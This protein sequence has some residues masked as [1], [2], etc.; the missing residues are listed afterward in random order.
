[1][2]TVWAL[3]FKCNYK[4]SL[5]SVV[6]NSKE[7]R[8]RWLMAAALLLAAF[9]NQLDGSI[10]NL[11]LPTIQADLN[12]SPSQLQWVMAIYTVAFASGLLP[13]GRFGDV[14]AR[15]RMF[16]GGLIGF[17][18]F[19]IICEIAPNIETLIVARAF[20][21]LAAGMM[22]P[23]VLAIIHVV[24]P[25]DKKGHVIGLF[26]MLSALGA[27]V[28][29]LVGG[30]LVSADVLGLGW[31]AIFL[32]NL[33]FGLISLVGALAFLPKVRSNVSKQAD[34]MGAVLFALAIICLT[35]PLIE[36]REL[37]WP[38]WMFCIMSFSVICGGG[39]VLWQ[40]YL[41][42]KNL[43]QTLPMSLMRDGSFI[44]G[45]FAVT[46]FF[47]GIAGVIL[48]L[49]F[50]LQSGLGF[51]AAQAGITM[52]AFPISVML[53]SLLAGYLGERWLDLRVFGGA[54][55]ILVG[56]LWLQF[57][58]GGA[59]KDIAGMEIQLPLFLTGAGMGSA[60]VALFQNVLSR[61]SGPDAGAGS[62]VL[63]AFQ[64]VGAALGIA[65]ICQIYFATLGETPDLT[66]FQHAAENALWLP[67][68]IYGLLCAISLWAFFKPKHKE[69]CKL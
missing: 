52:V 56:M 25:A 10:V 12:A 7:G 68:S 46:L 36:G 39:F 28:G 62:G 5:V 9:I 26:G 22:L 15:D 67:V 19:S 60:A 23:Q 13:F 63:Q 38:I 41:A 33:P 11:A 20:K 3:H 32:I 61:V 40:R 51:T 8:H 54:F 42:A 27:I 44:M 30:L 45:L 16:I 55:M 49:S 31:R 65:L 69:E 21:G 2:W 37:G 66:R 59:D 58:L 6:N 35:Y 1:M 43:I 18:I 50:F 14:F 24:F 4:V 34:W 53:A 57:I 48:L 29:P 47:T 17:M 64:Q